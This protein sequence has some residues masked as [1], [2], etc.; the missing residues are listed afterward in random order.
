MMTRS[1]YRSEFTRSSALKAVRLGLLR[2]APVSK[3]F[4]GRHGAKPVEFLVDSRAA[5][6]NLPLREV[7]VA[8][9]LQTLDYFEAIEVVVGVSRSG[10]IWGCL[11]AWSKNLPFAVVLPEGPRKSGLQRA[12][13]GEIWGKTIVLIDNFVRTGNSLDAAAHY[14]GLAGGRVVGA[15]VLVGKSRTTS[16]VPV[17]PVWTLAEVMSASLELGLIDAET[18]ERI[19]VNENEHN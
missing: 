16:P 13:E 3:P 6:A 18:H 5:A 19:L 8:E 11:A 14:A 7:I 12:V 17:T 2:F 9:L 1:K 4:P 15:T 10:V